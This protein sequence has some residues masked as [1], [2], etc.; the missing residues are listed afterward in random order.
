LRA[1]GPRTKRAASPLRA[2][3]AE[4]TFFYKSVRILSACIMLCQTQPKFKKG[5]FKK[6]ESQ[7]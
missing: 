5:K 3:S 4:P 1:H 2:N 7:N 6:M